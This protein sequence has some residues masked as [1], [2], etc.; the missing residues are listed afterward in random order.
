MNGRPAHSGYPEAGISAIEELWKILTDCMHANWGN[1]PVLGKGTLN[2]GLFN[3]GEAVNVIPGHA[4]ASVMIRTVE[5]RAYGEARLREIVGNRCGMDITA[6]GEPH[7]IDRGGGVWM[8][9]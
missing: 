7:I 4:R 5:P 1:D 3:G 9:V 8:E 2:V 6:G